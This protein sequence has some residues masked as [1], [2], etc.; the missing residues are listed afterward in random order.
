[1]KIKVS[2]IIPVYNVENY[3]ERCLES[4]IAQTYEN[5]EIIIINDGST[6]RSYELCK[7]ISSSDSRIMLINQKNSGLSAARNAGIE[8]ATGEYICFVDSDDWIEPDYIQFGMDI[9]IKNRIKLV[10]MGHY[11][12]SDDSDKL[13]TKGWISKEEK[14]VDVNEGMRLLLEDQEINSHAWDKIFHNSLFNTIRFPEGKN[15]EDIF[16]MH[17]IFSL[18]KKIGISKQPKYHYYIREDS[19]T[20]NYKTQNILDYFEA[21]FCRKKFVDKYYKDLVPLQNTKLMELLLSYYPKFL[22]KWSSSNSRFEEESN[23][24]KNYMKSILQDYQNS[25]CSFTENKFNVMYKVFKSSK[26]LF[27]VVSPIANSYLPRVKKSKYKSKIKAAI[28]K[29]KAFQ[30]NISNVSGLKKYILIGVP[31]YDNLGD[32][33]I[34]IS[35]IEYL[36]RYMP[37]DY[38]LWVITE[39]NFWKYFS[40]IKKAISSEDII[41]IQGGGNFGDQYYDQECLRRK[42]LS[43][44]SNEIVLMPATFYMKQLEKNIQDYVK[45]YSKNNFKIFVREKYSYEIIQRYFHNEVKLVPDIVLSLD[46]KCTSSLNRSGIG[47]C[48]RN[49]IERNISMK[50]ILLIKSE[51]LKLEKKI[52]VFDTCINKSIP[53]DEQ[54][55]LLGDCLNEISSYKLVITDKLHALIF[56]AITGTP[57]IAFGNYNYKIKGVYEWIQSLENIYYVESIECLKKYIEKM[58]HLDS[59]NN[60]IDLN[61][62][63]KFLEEQVRRKNEKIY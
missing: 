59:Q 41:Y 25:H 32:V 1:M 8:V 21:E 16:I 42:I 14:I 7:K 60:S 6:D 34:G 53:F 38:Y 39:K 40:E 5:I 2:I 22:R 43:N 51:L 49:D 44:F 20:R 26:G 30:D 24:F 31:E 61:N 54:K 11:V 10:V 58:Y 50:D 45:F 48:F 46:F 52:Y 3:V 56:C 15:F 47:V 4:I 62:Q 29:S 55:N 33:A 17:E 57:C 35:E 18:C 9:I 28:H 12:S 37:D 19:I 27:K 36:K 13:S 23:V 63:F